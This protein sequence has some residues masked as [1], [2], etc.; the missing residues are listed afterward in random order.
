M[1][2]F[3]AFILALL[4]TLSL[5]ACGGNDGTIGGESIKEA[6][7]QTPEEVVENFAG[8]SSLADY[9]GVFGFDPAAT[10]RNY[11]SLYINEKCGGS[12][13]ELRDQLLSGFP[14]ELGEW[15]SLAPIYYNGGNAYEVLSEG[16]IES[17]R[18]KLENAGSADELISIYVEAAMEVLSESFD[19]DPKGENE[20]ASVSNISKRELAGSEY[21]E[22]LDA[23][24]EYICEEYHGGVDYRVAFVYS[25][26]EVNSIYAMSFNYSSDGGMDYWDEV[27]Y[28]AETA[29]G[30]FIFT[31]GK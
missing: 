14:E 7:S 5:C 20:N 2:K 8:M 16:E 30:C 19:A 22:A 13:E 4:M 11:L 24:T 31:V 1:K 27:L 6:A 12:L 17:Y 18:S 25:P 28:V 10:L 26:G 21:N 15:G 3:T 9:C 29:N 23:L